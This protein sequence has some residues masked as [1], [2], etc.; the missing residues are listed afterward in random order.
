MGAHEKLQEQL[1]H[2]L[3]GQVRDL[4]LIAHEGH[5]LLE[6]TARSYYAK[7]MAQEMVLAELGKLAVVNRIDVQPSV[8]PGPWGASDDA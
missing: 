1:Q 5:V 3:R 6:G 2:R 4:R 7:Q 8:L